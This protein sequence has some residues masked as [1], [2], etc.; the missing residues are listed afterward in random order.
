V[1]IKDMPSTVSNRPGANP[2]CELAR[3]QR[4]AVWIP[5]TLSG[6]KV[7]AFAPN[8]GVAQYVLPELTRINRC[9]YWDYQRQKV[10]ARSS[11]AIKRTIRRAAKRTSVSKLPLNR[12]WVE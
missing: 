12:D 6:L 2:R 11:K 4:R 5:K 7:H 8:F 1:F 10:Y 3:Q 9:A